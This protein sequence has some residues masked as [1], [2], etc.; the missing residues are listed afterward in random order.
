MA[1]LGSDVQIR[2]VRL[3]GTASFLRLHSSDTLNDLAVRINETCKRSGSWSSGEWHLVNEGSHPPKAMLLEES[4]LTLQELGMWPGGSVRVS[5]EKPMAGSVKTEVSYA[6]RPAPSEVL[7]SH[8]GRF[9][10][11]PIAASQVRHQPFPPP[12]LALFSETCIEFLRCVLVFAS[13]PT[14]PPIPSLSTP[15]FSFHGMP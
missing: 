1:D 7:S 14:D 2:V 3:D 4:S 15:L 9:D 13:H 8:I 6:K 5:L 12:T 10:D 11:D